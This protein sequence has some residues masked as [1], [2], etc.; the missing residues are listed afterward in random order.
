M[1]VILGAGV[2][3]FVFYEEENIFGDKEAGFA[4]KDTSEIGR[5]YLVRTN[6]TAIDLKRTDSGWIVNDTYK[7]R[8]NTLKNLFWTLRTQFVQFPVPESAH[9]NAIKNLASSSVKVEVYNRDGDRMRSFYVGNEAHGYSGSYMLMEGAK[10]PYVVQ[11]PGVQG[12]PTPFYTTSL[13]DWR[14][15]GVFRFGKDNISHVTMRYANEPLNSFTVKQNGRVVVETEPGIAGTN[16]LNEKRAD[17]YLGFFSE[18]YC[19]GYMN[20]IPGLD[21]VIASADKYCSVE[22]LGK[23]NKRQ[24]LDVYYMP[25][26]KRSKN[27]TSEEPSNYDPDRYYGVTN[28]YKD[29]V[30]MQHLTL[31]KLFRKA[32]EFYQPE[33]QVTNP[34]AN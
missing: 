33:T 1:L 17:A 3:F 22:V 29:T 21:S 32:W 18:I 6:G 13:K 9:N 12:F 34:V 14:D 7:A 20:G 2:Y 11:V 26:N 24:Q 19:E 28:N 8:E 23:D 31:E 27:L 10:K 25:I 15:R 4:V 30:L 5:L 16:P